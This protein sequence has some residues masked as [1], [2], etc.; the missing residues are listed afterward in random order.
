MQL[1]KTSIESLRVLVNLTREQLD[2]LDTI[3]KDAQFSTGVKLYRSTI[4]GMMAEVLLRLEIRG[5][6]IRCA[7]DFWKR[8]SHSWA[9][10]PGLR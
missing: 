6:N 4:L 3:G 5:Q 2:H 8:V 10:N 7:E 1:T 9:R